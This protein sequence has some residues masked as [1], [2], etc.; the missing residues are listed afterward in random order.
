MAQKSN[1]S[2]DCDLFR[3]SGIHIANLKVNNSRAPYLFSLKR[4]GHPVGLLKVNAL[5]P[6]PPTTSP[7]KDMTS[8]LLSCPTAPYPT[9]LVSSSRVHRRVSTKCL[10]RM[11]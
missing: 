2:V 10:I 4:L 5:P 3:D 1:I 9:I 11:G 6:S 7:S 8:L